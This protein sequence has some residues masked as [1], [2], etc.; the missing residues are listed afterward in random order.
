MT[1]CNVEEVARSDKPKENHN[2]TAFPSSY[3][4]HLNIFQVIVLV[5]QPTTLIFWFFLTTLINPISR[6]LFSVKKLW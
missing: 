5:F 1:M 2:L 6:Q 3:M 4:K